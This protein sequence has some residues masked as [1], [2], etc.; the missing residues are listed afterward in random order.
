MNKQNFSVIDLSL[1]EA[2]HGVIGRRFQ[3][4]L[5]IGR[6]LDGVKQ[7]FRGRVL[8]VGAQHTRCDFRLLANQKLKQKKRNK[9]THKQD[10]TGVLWRF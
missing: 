6:P 4:H 9:Q 8:I 2:V 7:L 1:R 10:G 3:R 5:P